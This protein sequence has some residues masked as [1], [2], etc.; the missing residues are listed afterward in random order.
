MKTPKHMPQLRLTLLA[1]ALVLASLS[2]AQAAHAQTQPMQPQAQQ[3]SSAP[4]S[5]EGRV[6]DERTSAPLADVTVTVRETGA[7]TTTGRDGHYRLAPLAPGHYTL[8]FKAPKFGV[9]TQEITPAAGQLVREDVA[10][11]QIVRAYDKVTVVAQ[12]TTYALARDAQQDAENI[13]NVLAGKEIRKLPVVNAGDAVRRIPGVQLETDTGE[14]R[15]VNIRGL[16]SDLSST[17]FGGVRLPPTDVTTSPYGGSRAV[18][19]DNIPAAMIG[20]VTVTKTNRPEQEA[21]A[22]GGT[23]E[24]TPKTV[25]RYGKPFFADVKIGSGLE[26]LRHTGITDLSLTVGGR[27]GGLSDD[28]QDKNALPTRKPFSLLGVLSYYEDKRGVDDL[29]GSYVDQQAAGIPDKALLTFEQRY[30]RQHKVRH[31]Y[32]VEFGYSPEY[33]HRYYAR[34]YDFGAS[35][36]YNRNVLLFNFPGN[37][38]A[39]PDGTLVES[40]VT[41]NKYYRSNKETFDTRLFAVGGEDRF[42]RFNV[43]YFVARTIGSYDKPFDQIPVW[44]KLAADNA[45]PLTSTVAYN[46][47]ID[48]NFPRFSVIAGANPYDIAGYGLTGFSNSTQSSVTHDWSAKLNVTVPTHFSSYENEQVKFGLGARKRHFD[49]H[50]GVYLATGVPLIPLS[51]AAAGP[52]VTYYDGHYAMGPL[53]EPNAISAAFANGSG[54]TNDPVADAATAARSTYSVDENVYAAYGQYQTGFGKLGVFAGLRAEATR[55]RFDAFNVNSNNQIE[56]VSSSH[57][58]VD[59]LPSL[60]LRYAFND[61]LIGRAIYSSTIGRPGY[62]QQSPSLNINLPANLVSQGNPDIKPITSNNL[63]F[64]LEQYLPRGGIASVGLFYKQLKN[65]IVPQ[66]TIGTFPNQG[67]FAGFTGP[68]Q[69]ITF[70]NGSAARTMG[71]ELELEQRYSQ[72][73]EWLRGLG[74]SFN[75]TNVYSRIEIRPGEFTALPST[76]RHTA[77]A[78]VFLDRKDAFELSLGANYISRN[79]FA[80]GASAATDI[81]SEPRF[82]LDFGSRYVVNKTFSVYF[83]AKNLTNTALKFTEGA[84]NRPIQRETYGVTY[85]VGFS[86]HF[87]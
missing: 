66:G 21:E 7:T 15:F 3:P 83:N 75:L 80:I 45:T 19:F 14:G 73:P 39:Q 54:F 81:Y 62:N 32:G 35:Q 22:L 40:G 69:V 53:I 26:P 49:Q 82:S 65:Y 12:N 47:V 33:A 85:Q 44:T 18:S 23:I 71:L 10:L 61:G 31:A 51:Q 87:D 70:K 42:E 79:L 60:Q 11:G 78:T 43:D 17:T 48:P 16:D 64:S 37:P 77:N 58:Y 55:T 28:A 25:P 2:G 56:P 63:D 50:L 5:V 72:V 68:V 27:F 8:V 4:A 6:T 20:S 13:I 86:A 29:E 9:S 57:S 1:K 30:Y 76:A 24:I 46:N 34:Y 38:T 36:D 59:F 41:T 67:L 74:T 52:S 84:S